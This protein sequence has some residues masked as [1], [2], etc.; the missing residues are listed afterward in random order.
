MKYCFALDL[1]DSLPWFLSYEPYFSRLQKAV[2]GTQNRGGKK[3]IFFCVPSF[4]LP[5]LVR[6]K[7]INC[8]YEILFRTRP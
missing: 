4:H 8:C 1:K 2:W 3:V 6:I 5:N 7:V